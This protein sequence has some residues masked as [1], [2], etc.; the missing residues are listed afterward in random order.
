MAW[1]SGRN[2]LNGYEQNDVLVRGNKKKIMMVLAGQRC[3]AASVLLT[4]GEQKELVKQIV[5]K[6]TVL[7]PGSKVCG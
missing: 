6:A 2:D 4:V 7:V 3:M 5:E 1:E